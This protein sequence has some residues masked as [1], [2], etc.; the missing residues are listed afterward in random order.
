MKIDYLRTQFNDEL[1]SDGDVVEIAGSEFE[2]CEILNGLEP[3]TYELAFNEWLAEKRERLLEKADEILGMYDNQGR[4]DQLVRVHKAGN[5]VPFVGAG[6]SI[7]SGYPS[8]TAFLYKCCEESGI[9][10]SE[11]NQLL[12]DG[13]YEEA[14]Q[15]LHDDMT[16]PVFNELLDTTFDVERDIEGAIHYL[17]YLFNDKHVLTTNFDTVLERV[18]ESKE[19]AFDAG[20]VKSGRSLV[21]VARTLQTKP[22][23]LIKIHGTCNQVTDRVLLH[24]EY[25]TAYQNSGDVSNFFERVIFRDALL[26]LGASLSSDRTIKKMEELVT[27]KGHDSLPR[28]YAFLELKDGENRIERKRMLARANIFPIWYAEGEHDESIEALLYKLM[29]DCE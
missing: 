18:Y 20:S 4:F 23:S 11:L 17:P 24:S 16:S 5:L 8:W 13:L 2:R 14:A 15:L 1:N 29:K 27:E 28:H 6:I 3:D 10:E 12:S 26:F 21:E 7:P 22:R 25:V 9:A 19:K